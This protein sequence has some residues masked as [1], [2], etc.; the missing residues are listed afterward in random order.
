MKAKGSFDPNK[1]YDVT[2]EELRAIQERAKI[3][4]ALKEEY[5][6]KV[7]NPFRGPRGYIVRDLHILFNVSKSTL[8]WVNCPGI[9]VW[10]ASQ[11]MRTTDKR[12]CQSLQI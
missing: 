12:M 11:F 3:R 2:E 6:K 4:A 5:Q 9:C 7:T 8:Q 1:M 10:D